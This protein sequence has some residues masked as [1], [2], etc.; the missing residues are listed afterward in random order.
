M[1]KLDEI[2][3][4]ANKAENS[5]QL[6]NL[7]NEIIAGDHTYSEVEVAKE[8]FAELANELPDIGIK[9]DGVFEGVTITNTLDSGIFDLAKPP[10]GINYSD[11]KDRIGTYSGTIKLSEE[12]AERIKDLVKALKNIGVK[13]TF[14]QRVKQAWSVL[15][16]K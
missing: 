12:G 11:F 7:M 5:K 3:I 1:R 10:E 16:G 15:I 8:R 4:E 6:F 2:M 14:W 13:P 9:Y